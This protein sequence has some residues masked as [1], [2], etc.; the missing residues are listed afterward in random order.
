MSIDIVGS[1]M[2]VC[3][4]ISHLFLRVYVGMILLCVLQCVSKVA[5]SFQEVVNYKS[6]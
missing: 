4:N 1:P 3:T 5:M 6:N 2:N